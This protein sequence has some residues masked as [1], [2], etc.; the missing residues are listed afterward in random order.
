MKAKQYPYS[1]TF[2]GYGHYSYLIMFRGKEYR[3]TTSNMRAIDDMRSEEAQRDGRELRQL[4]GAKAL[5]SE[6]IRKHNLR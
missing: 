6:A 2:T 4:R 1:L 5:R 3:T